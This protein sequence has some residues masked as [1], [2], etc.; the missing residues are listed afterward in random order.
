M[1]QNI[2][3]DTLLWLIDEAIATWDEETGPVALYKL[4]ESVYRND[5]NAIRQYFSDGGTKTVLGSFIG[6][7]ITELYILDNSEGYVETMMILCERELRQNNSMNINIES[8]VRHAGNGYKAYNITLHNKFGSLATHLHTVNDDAYHN[9][10]YYKNNEF[11]AAV[12]DYRARCAAEKLATNIDQKERSYNN[13]MKI[14][15]EKA[16]GSDVKVEK[17]ACTV[18]ALSTVCGI[19]YDEA[20]KI[21]A[22][23]GRRPKRGFYSTLLLSYAEKTKGFNFHEIDFNGKT[24]KDFVSAYPTGKYFVTKRGHAFSVIDGVVKDNMLS[25]PRTKIY[26]AF[27]FGENPTAPVTPAPEEPKVKV[28][29]EKAIKAPVTAETFDKELFIAQ[30][31]A[32]G[33]PS[34]RKIPCSVTGKMITMF[35]TNLTNRVN[36]FGS[37]EALLENFVARGVK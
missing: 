28:V 30:Y 13:V 2:T 31:K 6:S 35:S 20:Y 7:N 11:D 17:N 34:C 8:E 19:P 33:K 22:A 4:K 27:E 15:I 9:G 16:T 25:G 32:T 23:A 12:K 24:L 29:K 14:K 1:K 18:I 10:H 21:A 36:K 26:S 37:V 3:I 5:Y